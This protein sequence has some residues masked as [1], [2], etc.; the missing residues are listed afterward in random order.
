[1]NFLEAVKILDKDCYSYMYR[2]DKFDKRL[3]LVNDELH[4]VEKQLYHDGTKKEYVPTA[5]D[6]LDDNLYE[7]KLKGL[8]FVGDEKDSQYDY[9]KVEKGKYF[10]KNDL[11]WV[12][13][14]IATVALSVFAICVCLEFYYVKEELAIMR[15]HNELALELRVKRIEEILE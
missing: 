7:R 3:H 5:K 8:G 2:K 12:L 9:T 6:M 15:Q 14:Y 13:I 10:M 11:K 4:Y 1:M